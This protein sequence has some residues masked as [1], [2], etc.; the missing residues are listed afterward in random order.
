VPL[1]AHRLHDFGDRGSV[2]PLQHW[3]C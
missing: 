2:L 1:P 3:V